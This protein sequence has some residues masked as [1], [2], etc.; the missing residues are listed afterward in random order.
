MLSRDCL[1]PS[2]SAPR[3]LR[4]AL[5]SRVASPL[6]YWC[7]RDSRGGHC[8][9]GVS[10]NEIL[11]QRVDGYSVMRALKLHTAAL[12]VTP[13]WGGYAKKWMYLPGAEARHFEVAK[14]GG[15]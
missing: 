4:C 3:S 6:R 9:Y 11:P 5:L 15:C 1:A 7:L 8:S 2:V 14:S 10:I 13:R 12:A